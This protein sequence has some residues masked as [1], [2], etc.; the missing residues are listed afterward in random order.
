MCQR[1]SCP[2]PKSSCPPKPSPPPCRPGPT[3]WTKLN[4]LPCNRLFFFVVGVG[5]GLYYDQMKQGMKDAQ[6]DSAKQAQKTP[7]EL[8]KEKKERE[9]KEKERK[10]KEK[11]E[12]AQQE[13]ERKEKEKKENK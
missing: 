8:E 2:P 5:I 1:P 6:E 7:K 11:K 10:E 3:L 12:K 9:K 4:C 13:K